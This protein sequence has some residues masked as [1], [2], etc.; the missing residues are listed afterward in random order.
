M[1]DVNEANLYGTWNCKR[2]DSVPL[3]KESTLKV[4]FDLNK[5]F[6]KNGESFTKGRLEFYYEMHKKRIFLSAYSIKKYFSWK[7]SHDNLVQKLHSINVEQLKS[8]KELLAFKSK[9]DALLNILYLKDEVSSSKVER[10]GLDKLI[11]NS[12]CNNDVLIKI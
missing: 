6:L 12:V 7:I 9:I 3:N 10:I 8:S 4:H 2:I 11:L 1:A 5:T